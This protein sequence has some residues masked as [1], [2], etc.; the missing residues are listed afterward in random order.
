VLAQASDA[1]LD[2]LIVSH[3]VARGL[4]A[5]VVTV[6][7]AAPLAAQQPT[8]VIT[9]EHDHLTLHAQGV[10]LTDIVRELGLQ[11][12]AEIV[13]A[14]RKPRDVSQDFEGV[15]LVDGLGRLLREQNFTLR[16][17]PEGTLRAIALLGEPL[18]PAAQGTPPAEASE[19][20]KSVPGRRA[21]GVRESRETLP[22][23]QVLVTVSGSG[24][25]GAR[26]KSRGRDGS[27]GTPDSPA[28]L[29][30][31]LQPGTTA[32]QDQSNQ[33]NGP[34]TG[35]ELERKLRRSFLN[36]LD[37]MDEAALAA[38]LATP[39]GQRIAALLQYY[40]AHHPSSSSYEKANGI[41]DRVPDQR[42][43]APHG[44]R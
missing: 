17:G 30:G 38:Y 22:D 18:A 3:D 9:Y 6:L 39:E 19:S 36:D 40:A 29:G 43:S 10:P 20:G 21:G 32:P 4:L 25:R 7:L 28:I 41:L 2:L 11:S 8:C 27:G 23:G 34:L 37:Q 24:R 12:G 13:G 33:D 42:N 31:L 16:Y 35:D 44:H 15:S 1:G 5:V 26:H 14:V